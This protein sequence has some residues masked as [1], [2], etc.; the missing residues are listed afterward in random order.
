MTVRR[1]SEILEWVES[2]TYSEVIER[3]TSEKLETAFKCPECGTTLSGDEN[4]CG[5]CG[6]KLWCR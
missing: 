4:F 2:G 5:M 1:A 3:R 6:S